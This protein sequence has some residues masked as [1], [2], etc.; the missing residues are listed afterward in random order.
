MHRQRNQ[1]NK[2]CFELWSA[3]APARQIW[4]AESL[5]FSD[6]ISLCL[7][8]KISQRQNVF[9]SK[10][11]INPPSF[12]LSLDTR[13][14]RSAITNVWV[15]MGFTIQSKQM[16]S[17]YKYSNYHYSFLLLALGERTSASQGRADCSWSGLVSLQCPVLVSS[18]VF[19][20][21]TIVWARE[22]TRV[23]ARVRTSRELYWQ[24]LK[25]NRNGKFLNPLR[26]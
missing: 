2:S 11:V 3:R 19:G 24:P 1:L 6:L 15:F 20:A 16:F 18:P 13:F 7:S 5:K 4:V 17:A 22:A 23:L 26:T 12:F 14:Q 9:F 25:Y 21:C 8:P 10:K